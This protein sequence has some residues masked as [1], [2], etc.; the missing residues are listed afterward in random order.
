MATGLGKTILF[1]HV[2]RCWPKGRVMVMAHREELIFQAAKKVG[3]INNDQ[4][5][6]EMGEMESP[7]NHMFRPRIVVSS[8]QTLN[9]RRN[10]VYRMERFDPMEFGLLISDEAHHSCA[11]TYRRVYDWFSKNPELRHLGVTATPD[12]ADEEALGQIYDSVAYEYGIID[13]INDGW[14]VPIEQQYVHIDGLDL[15]GCRADKHDLNDSD[16]AAI[17]ELEKPLHG[18]V[19]AS[20]SLCGGRPAIVFAASVAHAERMAEI[21]N[22]HR[23]GSAV[24]I[25]G[26]TPKD[27][28]RHHLER[29]AAGDFQWLCNMGVFLEGFDEPRVSAIVMARPTK[30]RALYS[31]CVGRATRP[32]SGLIDGTSDPD[33]RKLLISQ[34]G[35][36]NM[37]VLDFVGNSGRH[38]L[39]STADILSG[40]ESD[41]V[42]ERAAENAKKKNREGKSADMLAEL[43]RARRELAEEAKRKRRM[44]VA[45]AKFTTKSVSPFD[46]FDILPKREP[47]WHKGR[48]PTDRMKAALAKF[49]L[50]SDEIERMSFWDAKQVLDKLIDRSRRGLCTYGQAKTLARYGYDTEMTFSEASATI[51]RLAK[52]GWKP[53]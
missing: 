4:C 15:S 32:Q 24:C 16:V 44:L 9:S 48:L 34:S 19:D 3:S 33:H 37:L 51:D 36:P 8:V 52:N 39:V 53:I 47:G 13:G 29:F 31:Q 10:G 23:A 28:R 41:A 18:V 40:N 14:L 43:E 46:V 6:I 30:S 22:R 50:P 17:M 25:T 7:E 27:E 12:R 26:T 2:A 5:G 38:K 42:I 11:A 20:I 45:K 35:K 21:F 49:R 1:A